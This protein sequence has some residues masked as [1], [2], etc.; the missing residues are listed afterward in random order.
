MGDAALPRGV[1]A[2][3]VVTL[4]AAVALPRLPFHDHL[5]RHQQSDRRWF[6]GVFI[7]SGRIVD[8]GAHRLKTALHEIVTRLRPGVRLTASRT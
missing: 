2:A 1:R 4:G 3:R 8:T 7:Q 6:Y 5:G